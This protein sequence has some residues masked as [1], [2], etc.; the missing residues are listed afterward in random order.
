M[1]WR[2]DKRTRTRQKRGEGRQRSRFLTSRMSC[3]VLPKAQWDSKATENRWWQDSLGYILDISSSRCC[4]FSGLQTLL[5]GW[6]MRSPWS[7]LQTCVAETLSSP[8][9]VFSPLITKGFP[10]KI[11]ITMK[12]LWPLYFSLSVF[13]SNEFYLSNLK[14][15]EIRYEFSYDLNNEHQLQ[16]PVCTF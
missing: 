1:I 16:E 9:V 11:W 4:Y 10:E 7:S 12:F 3:E 2:F 6:R 15:A 13:T 8:R 14:P 5:Q